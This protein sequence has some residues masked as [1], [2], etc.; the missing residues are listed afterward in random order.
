MTDGLTVSVT[1]KGKE[2]KSTRGGQ[3]AVMLGPTTKAGAL[4]ICCATL[5]QPPASKA[6]TLFA[7]LA[8]R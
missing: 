8:L 6:L 4:T 3:I 2:K 7:K 5:L 1:S